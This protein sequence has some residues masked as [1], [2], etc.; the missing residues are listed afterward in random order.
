MGYEIIL[1]SYMG[2]LRRAW[3]SMERSSP[4][5]PLRA[6]NQSRSTLHFFR[7]PSDDLETFLQHDM[8][9]LSLRLDR[10]DERF[11][12]F[13]KSHARDKEERRRDHYE[14]MA[15]LRS[16]F[17]PLVPQV[18]VFSTLVPPSC[19]FFMLPKRGDIFFLGV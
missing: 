18:L 2:R 15:Y 8:W 1:L 17:S 4:S 9:A 10:H 16:L 6:Y 5:P 3:I 14:I 12:Q 13:T 11:T 19:F 7:D